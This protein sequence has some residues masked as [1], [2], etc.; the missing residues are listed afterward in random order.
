MKK[1][2]GGVVINGNGQEK[3]LKI[4]VYPPPPPSSIPLLSIFPYNL[5]L[6]GRDYLS[7]LSRKEIGFSNLSKVQISNMAV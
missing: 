2:I 1:L 6:E 3:Y 5:E 4:E 7:K